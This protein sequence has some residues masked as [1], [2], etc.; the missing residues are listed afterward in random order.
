[1]YY[2]NMFDENICRV[3][4]IDKKYASRVN[5]QKI[6]ETCYKNWK[7]KKSYWKAM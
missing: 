3:S 4:N 2:F 1:M 5:V 7:I 6:Y